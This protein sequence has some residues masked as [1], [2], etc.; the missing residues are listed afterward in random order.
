MR[1]ADPIR[2]Q[3]FLSEAGVC[4]RRAAE[5]LISAGEV[6]VNGRPAE[7]GQRVDSGL[8]KVTVGG[9]PVRTA[10][11]PLMTLVVNKPRGLV[12]S[13][14]DP[15]NAATVFDLLP[16][17]LSKFRFFCAGRLDKDSE[18]LLV[19]TTDGAL[20]HRLMHPSTLVVK[21]YHVRLEEP[22]PYTR[23][24]H[25]LRGLTIEGERMKVEHAALVNPRPDRSS[26]D[27]DVWM[28]H[29]KKREIR[30][31]F[32]ALGYSV[33]RL[34]R[35]QIGTFPLRGIPLRG[36]KQ[37]STKEIQQLFATPSSRREKKPSS[38]TIDHES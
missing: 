17:E 14:D 3:K 34:R 5:A 1:D 23:M 10:P 18:G 31:L 4:S 26:N 35:Y 13:N 7:L 27:L 9:K 30:Q 12:C 25:L 29:G 28:H 11:Q 32:L 21:R 38:P 6:W 36:V 19:L 8:D 37:L 16:R 15:H 33:K 24:R 22:F 20:A 2:L